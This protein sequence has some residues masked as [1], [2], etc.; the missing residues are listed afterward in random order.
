MPLTAGL[1]GCVDRS[2]EVMQHL[3]MSLICKIPLPPPQSHSSHTC[4][5][6]YCHHAPC[7]AADGSCLGMIMMQSNRGCRCYPNNMTSMYDS[8]HYHNHHH[9]H[10]YYSGPFQLLDLAQTS[11]HPSTK[12]SFYLADC[13]PIYTRVY[14]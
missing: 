7:C 6:Q 4:C 14:Y 9:H 5:W 8:D 3:C 10:M 12:T 2:V 11:H 13:R 1:C